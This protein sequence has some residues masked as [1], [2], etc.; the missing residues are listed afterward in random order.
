MPT[1]SR[2]RPRENLMHPIRWVPEDARSLLDVG[3]NE[4]AFLEYAGGLWPSLRL[5]GVEINA[6]ALKEARR[7]LPE[8]ELHEAPA[9]AL[10]FPDASFDCVA[11]IEVIEHVGAAYRAPALREAHRVLR[12]GGRF[13]LR[14]PHA[15]LFAWLDP[16]NVRHRVPGL[17]RRVL[18]RGRRDL[19]YERRTEGVIWHHHFRQDELLELL[20]PGWRLEHVRRGALAIAP[21]MDIA[22]WPFYRLGRVDGPLIRLLNRAAELDLAVDYGRYSY[23]ILLVMSKL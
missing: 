8:A 5:A 16:Q 22:R 1:E 12:S 7:R 18:G 9:E 17:Y 19:A 6:T 14:A 3:C 15:G 11:C 10:P 23:D 4:G 21:L 20:G 2:S 13:L